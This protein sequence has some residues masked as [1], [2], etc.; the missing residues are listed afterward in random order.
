[1]RRVEDEPATAGA[2]NAGVRQRIDALYRDQAPA[3]A[4]RL[5]SRVGSSE[6]ARD[7][8]QDAFARLL[9]TD[10]ERSVVR[11]EAFLARIL[12]N[13]LIDRSRRLVTRAVHVPIEAE[14]EPVVPA[15][16]AAE[17]EAADLHARYREA[18]A[19]LPPRMREVFLLH[20]VE[21][22]AYRE[23]AER[24]G[25]GIRTVEWHFAEA[26]LR[27]ARALEDQ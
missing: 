12:R 4:R 17:L 26:M 16:Q 13:L 24:L 3:I 20:R 10:V 7:L 8:V 25:I 9:G 22:L 1:M 15:S 2:P 23:I 19:T 27:L 6:D 18:V 14:T 21:E 11:P 5:Q